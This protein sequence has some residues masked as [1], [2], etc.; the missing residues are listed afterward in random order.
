MICQVCSASTILCPLFSGL[1][2]LIHTD[3]VSLTLEKGGGGGG[4]GRPKISTVCGLGI[5]MMETRFLAFEAT[6]QASQA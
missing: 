2:P 4:G 1:A 5:A 6:H 3:V